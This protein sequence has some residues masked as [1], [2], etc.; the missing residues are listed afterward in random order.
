MKATVLIAAAALLCGTAAFAQQDRSVRG[1]ES[2]RVDQQDHGRVSDKMRNGAHRL[3]AKTRHAMHRLGDKTHHAS[4]RA[5]NDRHE[6]H[7]RSDRGERHG[8]YDTDTRAMGA[9]GARDVDT[10]RRGRMDSAYD[11]WRA[12]Q[13]R[14]TGR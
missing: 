7:A 5:R 12:R 4:S 11:N 9:A 10:D 6:Q 14:T 8:R 2:A 1:E 13:E 3:G